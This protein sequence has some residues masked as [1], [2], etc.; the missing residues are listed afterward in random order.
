VVEYESGLSALPPFFQPDLALGPI[1][2]TVNPLSGSLHVVSIGQ[3]G[4]LTLAFDEPVANHPGQPDFI[5]YGNA[6]YSNSVE[7]VHFQEPG[8][9]EVGLD[10]NKNGQPDNGEP[11]Y[12]LGLGMEPAPGSPPQFPIPSEY[13]GNVDHELLPTAGY[14]DV[15]PVRGSGDPRIPDDPMAP[16][17]TEGSAGGDAFDLDWAVDET[18]TPVD[19]EAVDFIRIHNAFAGTDNVGAPGASSTEVDAVADL[20][21]LAVPRIPVSRWELW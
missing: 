21:V 6:F 14:C 9:V 3:N 5:V 11:F 20:P 18:G 1:A 12:L 8:W 4:Y 7:R 13:S 10:L 19:L 2:E 15:T 17:L 16:G